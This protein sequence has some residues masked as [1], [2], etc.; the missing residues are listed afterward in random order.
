MH[1]PKSDNR[2]MRMRMRI[3]EISTS[4]FLPLH[5]RVS[6]SSLGFSILRIFK[7]FNF[8]PTMIRNIQ[9]MGQGYMRCN[10]FC[11]QLVGAFQQIKYAGCSVKGVFGKQ[12]GF[13][14]FFFFFDFFK[15]VKYDIG[16]CSLKFLFFIFCPLYF[17]S[18]YRWYLSYGKRWK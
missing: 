12:L 7:S 8:D 3:L 6:F 1:I 5:R 17:N 11:L 9:Y 18:Y 15:W 2:I 13:W 14:F 16:T 4:T 10:R